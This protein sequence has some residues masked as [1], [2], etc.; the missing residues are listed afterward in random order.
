[1]IVR[2]WP[3]FR[4]NLGYHAA[5]A[6]IS[7]TKAWIRGTEALFDKILARWNGVLIDSDAFSL[8]IGPTSS[9]EVNGSLAATARTIWIGHGR[10][11]LRS[12]ESGEGGIRTRGTLRYT[13]SPGVRI[14]PD[15]AT[16]PNNAWRLSP[17]GERIIP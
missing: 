4:A 11:L 14:R 9:E 2:I 17:P 1:M 3:F 7:L 10:A 16:S 12:P 8:Q 13:R 5:N 15:Y 6:P